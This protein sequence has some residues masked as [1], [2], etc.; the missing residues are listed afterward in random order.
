MNY[1][2]EGVYRGADLGERIA[3]LIQQKKLTE[4]RQLFEAEQAQKQRDA[5]KALND[6]RLLAEA[7]RLQSQQTFESGQGNVQRQFQG[8]EAEKQRQME[9]DIANK[10]I[11]AEAPLRNAETAGWIANANLRDQRGDDLSMA[12]VTETD[13]TDPNKKYQYRV[14]VSSLTQ[15]G[16]TPPAPSPYD[17]KLSDLGAQIAAQKMLQAQGNQ[18][19]WYGRNRQSIIDELQGNY[20][21]ISKLKGAGSSPTAPAA[22]LPGAA[23]PSTALPAIPGA[24]QALSWAQANP[25]DPKAQL[26]LQRLGRPGL[27]P[28]AGTLPPLSSLRAAPTSSDEDEGD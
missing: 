13:P 12:S 17:S 26:I 11:E 19:T 22:G 7:Q 27:P 5:E 9:Q 25:T 8:T 1:F 21:A 15:P 6:S 16:A 18:H 2:A 23:A 3:E 24:A 20:D 10:R 4:A 28:A 14:P